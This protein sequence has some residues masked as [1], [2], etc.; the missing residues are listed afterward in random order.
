TSRLTSTRS[1][2][3]SSMKST[4]ATAS[5][6]VLP[7]VMFFATRSAEPGAYRPC[8]L[9]SRASFCRRSREAFAL[10]TL[11]SAMV[12]WKPAMARTWAMP[13]PMYPAPTMVTV[14]M[15]MRNSFVRVDRP[16]CAG[17]C[18]R[19]SPC[20]VIGREPLRPVYES[21]WIFA[22]ASW[23]SGPV[24][25][26][27]VPPRPPS[28]G[29]RTA[30]R[31]QCMCLPPSTL[32]EVPL[33]KLESSLTRKLIRP[34]TSSGWPTRCSGMFEDI[35]ALRSSVRVP[36]MMSVSIGP[37]RITFAVM[38]CSPSSR[39]ALAGGGSGEAVHGGVGGGVAGLGGGAA[40][41]ERRD[42]GGVDDPAAHAAVDH[43]PGAGLHHQQGALAVGAHHPV[44]GLRGD[45]EE[46]VGA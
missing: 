43:A 32:I 28:G 46:C 27:A 23:T 19:R 11:T 22:R 13:P 36:P 38:P 8:S 34:A 5:S 21:Y 44:P 2:T 18:R 17:R 6:R 42:R 16:R 4:S 25:G 9:K 7:A 29:R 30:G 37:G 26:R 45:V 40:A 3:A 41:V 39:A 24:A 33:T 35:P 15:V 31:A 12:T 14:E 1:K 20:V 10:S